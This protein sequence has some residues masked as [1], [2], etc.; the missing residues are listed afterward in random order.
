MAVYLQ[1]CLDTEISATCHC[2]EKTHENGLE[3]KDTNQQKLVSL[4]G[5]LNTPFPIELC[6]SCRFVPFI[7][8]AQNRA[9]DVVMCSARTSQP[10]FCSA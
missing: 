8:F 3:W 7:V 6:K 2:V 10:T 5:A 4:G 9:V 1:T